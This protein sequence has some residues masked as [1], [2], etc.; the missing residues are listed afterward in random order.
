MSY[1]VAQPGGK[2]RPATVTVA[3]ILLYVF[4]ALQVISILVSL[5]TLGPIRAAVDEA[6]AGLPGA[7]AAQGVFI[8]SI[9]LGV[10]V[11]AVFAVGA[12]VLGFLVGRGKNPARIVTWVFASL[13]VL[14]LGCGLAADAVSNSLTGTLGAGAADPDMQEAQQRIL[15][16]VPAWANTANAV[17]TIVAL[18]VLLAIIVLLALPASNDYFRKEQEVWVPPTFP[19]GT[20]QTPTTPPAPPTPPAQ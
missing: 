4:A 1:T 3:S 2:Q 17:L 20:G 14:C 6:L 16:A 10:I 19:G 18:I 15:E 9:V 5:A 7:E 11:G 13:G 8:I 12:A